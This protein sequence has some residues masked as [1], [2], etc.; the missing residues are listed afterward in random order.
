MQAV[1][2]LPSR[3]LSVYTHTP[4]EPKLSGKPAGLCNQVVTPGAGL[5]W[6]VDSHL[7][8]WLGWI[9]WEEEEGIVLW[10]KQTPLFLIPGAPRE[11]RA[12][13]SISEPSL[14]LASVSPTVSF[15][16]PGPCKPQIESKP[17][18]GLLNRPK[19]SEERGPGC[20]FDHKHQI[21][22]STS[23]LGEFSCSRCCTANL[24]IPS[25]RL[26][27]LFQGLAERQRSNTGSF[28]LLGRVLWS[29]ERL[30]WGLS[31]LSAFHGHLP[32]S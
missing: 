17:A 25:R 6:K 2:C 31:L 3:P 8:R 22:F 28:W 15:A 19:L 10:E 5:H 1:S 32:L 20:Y 9:S 14:G 18:L 23:R 7:I 12:L 27:R 16:S 11:S 4:P 29:H 13:V 21:C 30:L 24:R 26:G